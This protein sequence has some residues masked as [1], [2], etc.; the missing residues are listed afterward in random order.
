[1]SESKDKLHAPCSGICKIRRNDKIISCFS[2]ETVF[3]FKCAELSNEEYSAITQN[4]NSGCVYLCVLCRVNVKIN[5]NSSEETNMKNEIKQLKDQITLLNSN[6]DL[7]LSKLENTMGFN[8]ENKLNDGLKNIEVR[9]SK[10]VET[11]GKQITNKVDTNG[12]TVQNKIMSYAE[13]VSSNSSSSKQ[14]EV[15][16]QIDK[17][18]EG[19]KNDL[20][21]KFVNEKE[22]QLESKLIESRKNN[23]CVFYLPESTNPN[24]EEAYKEDINKLKSI[25]AEKVEL[26]Q[27]D[28]LEVYRKETKNK[29]NARPIIIKLSS[30]EKKI[31][32]LQL[33]DL[34]YTNDAVETKIFISPDRTLQQQKKHK[35][36]VK[37]L[38]ERRAKGEEGLIIKN[39]RI[40]QRKLPFRKSP[41]SYWGID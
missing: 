5:H 6:L 30:F 27:E 12:K 37:E 40:T 3:H 38:Q 8:P 11:L 26:K 23:V 25:F 17:K 16:T 31:E 41:Q 22:S 13:K 21:N 34:C 1:M 28:I 33:R 15:L 4:E 29:S 24:Q 19:L 35:E 18:F 32:I 20:N 2:C 7:R 36:L 9:I 14:S 39:E 10:K